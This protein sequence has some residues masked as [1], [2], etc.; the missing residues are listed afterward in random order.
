MNSE[1]AT[2]T[3]FWHPKALWHDRVLLVVL[4]RGG[5]APAGLFRHRG[6]VA[7]D[8]DRV[9]VALVG[10]GHLARGTDTF[11][12]PRRPRSSHPGGSGQRRPRICQSPAPARLSRGARLAK[13]QSL[14]ARGVSRSWAQQPDVRSMRYCPSCW[15]WG[16]TEVSGGGP[17][18]VY[19]LHVGLISTASRTPSSPESPR[20]GPRATSPATPLLEARSPSQALPDS[21]RSLDM[22]SS[23]SLHTVSCRLS[24]LL[25]M[26]RGGRPWTN[27]S[28][29]RSA[30]AAL[31]TRSCPTR[32]PKCGWT[33]I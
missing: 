20:T 19:W 21:P 18:R 8:R 27:E 16:R 4:H 28:G 11:F 13:R 26:A 10:V 12:Q 24:G 14:R 15:D 3:H 29:H 23:R 30:I 2:G 31:S 9:E 7:N 25:E 17:K 1:L 32:S 22:Q 33:A 5:G 6:Q